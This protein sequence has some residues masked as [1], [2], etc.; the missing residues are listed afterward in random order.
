MWNKA[1]AVLTHRHS[2]RCCRMVA[3]GV[4]V[5]VIANML[6]MHHLFAHMSKGY[7][8]VMGSVIDHA[9]FED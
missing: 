2:K 4:V 7:E 9:I 3:V 1:K 6:E 8:F 5:I